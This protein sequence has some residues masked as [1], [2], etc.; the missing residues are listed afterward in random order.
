QLQNNVKITNQISARSGLKTIGS[1][2]MMQAFY[3]D[4]PSGGVWWD[5]VKSKV[6]SWSNAGIDAIWLPPASKAQNGAYSMGYD[7]YDYFDL[8]QYN[9]KGSTETRFGSL[10][11]LQSLI[12]TAHSSQL[13]V[14]A[15]I[16]INHNSG[17][18]SEINPYTGGNTWTDFNPLSGKFYRSAT[19]FHA[20]NLHS[21]DS[22]AFGGFPD[23]CHHQTYVQDWLWNN[24]NSVAKYYK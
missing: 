7:P 22:G 3:W 10:A 17:G 5:T 18:D 14:I 24:T 19:D 6:Q 12:N 4:V 1:G 21:N 16:V 11:E 8:G 20:N 23:L 9:Q 13:N 2:V 15:D